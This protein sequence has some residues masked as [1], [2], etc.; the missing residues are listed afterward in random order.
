[1][2]YI[3]TSLNF[4][5]IESASSLNVP[6]I[7]I[8]LARLR[9]LREEKK[10][11]DDSEPVKSLLRL[12]ADFAGVSQ[13]LLFDDIHNALNAIAS[14][15]FPAKK[16]A[17]EA[18]EEE[19]SRK[20]EEETISLQEYHYRLVAQLV[21]TELCSLGDALKITSELPFKDVEGILAARIRF[22]NRAE[23]EKEKE[24]KERQEIGKEISNELQ[25][26]SFFASNNFFDAVNNAMDGNQGGLAGLL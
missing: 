1:M 5:F 13:E 25:E 9:E 20:S 15:N 10:L 8:C 18:I 19:K 26:G 17:D 7:E 6:K 2:L 24:N 3:D 11:S 23:I 14:V 12:I 16:V 4:H 22:L 21:N